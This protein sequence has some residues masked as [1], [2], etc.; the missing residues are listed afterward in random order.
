[1]KNVR[2]KKPRLDTFLK[3]RD[4]QLH[5]RDRFIRSTSRRNPLVHIDYSLFLDKD[6][7]FDSRFLELV[8]D[9]IR[10]FKLR[11]YFVMVSWWGRGDRALWTG[12]HL[13]K[14][15]HEFQREGLCEVLLSYQEGTV[16]P[17]GLCRWCRRRGIEVLQ[18]DRHRLISRN[19]DE[20][21]PKGVPGKAEN[22][23]K[24]VKLIERRVKEEGIPARKTLVIFVDDD[25]T[26]FHWINYFLLLAPWVLSFGND[27]GDP[28]LNSVIAGIQKVGFIKSGSPRII[29]PYQLQDEIVCGRIRPMDYLEVTLAV[30]ELASAQPRWRSAADES[31]IEELRRR[32]G[33]IRRRKQI[34]TPRNRAEILGETLNERLE[35]L[36]R[37]NI[38]R[39][40]RVTQQLE[41]I[42]R[43]L[44]H[45]SHC[46]WLRQLT[47]ILHGDQGAP[48]DAW[49]KFSPFGGYA[50]EMSLLMQA[51]CDK[52]FEDHQIL[53]ILGLPHSHQRSKELA[54]WR[55]LDTILLTFD[56]TRVLYKDLALNSF[57][58]VYGYRR[59]F[60]MLDRYGDIVQHSPDYGGLKIY[61]P[62][63]RLN[64]E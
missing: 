47:F 6:H 45:K 40:G 16:S 26:Q 20:V 58:S 28:S 64:I 25:Y 57:L 41:G 53:N 27:S 36:W 38:Y 52:S 54:I 62:L 46:R 44:S 35:I 9:N 50:L 4:I 33:K 8:K 60:P 34:F 48:L 30:L 23:I 10:R 32:L 14:T 19:G 12:R 42:L 43:Y 21:V 5:N 22:V 7:R 37:E 39:G 55:M 15:L 61:P 24:S 49:L 31:E 63:K 2:G 13:L 29:L 59:Q 56:L 11:V 51:M 18:V 17:S 3:Q 1:M